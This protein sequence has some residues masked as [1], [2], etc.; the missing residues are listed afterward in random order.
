MASFRTA[1][2]SVERRDHR[3]SQKEP[4]YRCLTRDATPKLLNPTLG[5]ESV[6]IEWVIQR[7]GPCWRIE[8]DL[9]LDSDYVSG[10]GVVGPVPVPIWGLVQ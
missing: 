5:V 10:I 9:L 4:T 6:L 2:S 8:R 1:G 3:R 7:P